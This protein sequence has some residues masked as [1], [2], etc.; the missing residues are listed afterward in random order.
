MT[1][2]APGRPL[3]ELETRHLSVLLSTYQTA[4]RFKDQLEDNVLELQQSGA[5]VRSIARALGVGPTTVHTWAK[6]A[7]LRKG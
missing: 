6:N 2:T 3:T 4:H 7:R 1:G 5:S